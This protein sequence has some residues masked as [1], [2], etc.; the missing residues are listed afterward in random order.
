MKSNFYNS[1][2]TYLHR[3][4]QSEYVSGMRMHIKRGRIAKTYKHNP[5]GYHRELVR[6]LGLNDEVGF[7]QLKNETGYSSAIGH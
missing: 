3:L 2:Q 7:K 4:A 1:A 6:L 5:S